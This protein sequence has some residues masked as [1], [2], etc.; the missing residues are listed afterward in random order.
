MNNWRSRSILYFIVGLGGFLS[1]HY[2]A[3][4][5]TQDRRIILLNTT[6]PDFHHFLGLEGQD[7]TSVS[8]GQLREYFDYFHLVNEAMPDNSDGMLMSGY[9]Y[10]IAGDKAQAQVFLNKAYHL[11][12]SFFFIDFDLGLLSFEQGDRSQ[13][14]DLLQ[15]ALA[16]PPQSTINRMMNSIIYRQLFSSMDNSNDII[17][18]LHQAYQDA[19]VL[20]NAALQKGT[21]TANATTP[22]VH[23]HIF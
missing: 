10:E 11:D 17:V 15:K 13:S 18:G 9:L 22:S 21:P 4:H 12:P 19:Y 8:K 3:S 20:L 1:L 5:F 14:I 16:I 7:T 23:A 2:T 6:R